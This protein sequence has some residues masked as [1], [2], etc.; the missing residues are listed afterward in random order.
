MKLTIH[1]D[2]GSRGNPG[3]AGAG[4]MIQD[5]GGHSLLEAGYFLG[6]MTNN[7]AEYHGLLKALDAC[8]A[9][10]ATDV[11]FI[12]DSELMARQLNGEYRVRNETLKD[13]FDQASARLRRITKWRIR[14]VRREAN[15][16]ADKLANAAMDAEEDVVE[17]DRLSMKDGAGA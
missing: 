13:L 1:I 6:R 14:H 2:G 12:C 17:L 8:L 15:E 7:M 4:V 11:Q 16:R 9:C 5:D 3:P 10:G